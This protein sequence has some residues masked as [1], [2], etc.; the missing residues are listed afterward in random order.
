M[1]IHH[2]GWTINAL[3]KCRRSSV[4]NYT[5]HCLLYLTL[6]HFKSLMIRDLS[7]RSDFSQ[8]KKRE[9]KSIRV[10]VVYSLILLFRILVHK[11]PEFSSVRIFVNFSIF[12]LFNFFFLSQSISLSKFLFMKVFL[13]PIWIFCSFF[14]RKQSIPIESITTCWLIEHRR[15]SN[16]SRENNF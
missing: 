3:E 1:C 12:Y 6:L 2:I 11:R 10:L 4:I 9:N 8:R 15:E 5:F 7:L 14:R 16:R 13:F